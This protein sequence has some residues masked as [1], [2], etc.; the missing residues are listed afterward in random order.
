MLTD[1]KTFSR[2]FIGALL[3]LVF[4]A[5]TP[6]ATTLFNC[7]DAPQEYNITYDRDLNASENITHHEINVDHLVGDGMEMEANC[8]CPKNMSGTTP[9]LELTLAGSPLSPGVSGYGYLTDKVDIDVRGYT[10][11]VNSPD[12]G[13]LFGLNINQYPT[14]FSSM[15]NTIEDIKTKEG[16]ASVCS[17]STRPSDSTS[18]KRKFKL[19]VIGAKFYIK[20]PI[21]GKEAIPTTLVVQNYTCLYFGSGSCDTT[22]AQQVSNIWLSGSL[23]APLSCTINEGSTIE[24]DFGNIVSKQFN[25]KS[26]P[27]QGYVLKNVDIS[28]H[29]DDNAIGNNDRIKLTLTADQGVVDSSEPLVA[30]MLDKDDVGVRIYDENNQNVALDGTFE[31][32]VPMDDQGNGVVRIKAAPVST[33]GKTPEPGQFEGNVTVKMDLR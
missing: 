3:C 2:A 29:C 20:K 18:V 26:R 15:P 4:S 32:P 16:T 30:K 13:G 31:F 8:S 6:A 28:Y 27:P 19:N 23:S 17:A 1:M 21:I 11:A 33:T 22:G 24:V 14:S 25:G 10:D 9:V 5:S 7:F 12:G